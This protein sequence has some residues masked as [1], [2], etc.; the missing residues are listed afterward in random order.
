MRNFPKHL[1]SKQ[2]FM[3]CLNDYPAE[4]KA[5]LQTLLDNRF[6]WVD[7]AII[8][9]EGITDETHR[10]LTDEDGTKTQQELI[11]DTHARIFRLGFTVEEV[12]GLLK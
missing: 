1:N 10:V 7:T 6:V 8:E 4:T 3:N 11:E 12:E 5:E 9:N 2:D